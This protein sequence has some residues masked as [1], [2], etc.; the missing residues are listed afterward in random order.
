M[1]KCR[2]GPCSIII[3]QYLYE[4]NSHEQIENTHT[5]EHMHDLIV[6]RKQIKMQWLNDFFLVLPSIVTPTCKKETENVSQPLRTD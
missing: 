1:V 6:K 2:A 4:V 5:Y 3:I